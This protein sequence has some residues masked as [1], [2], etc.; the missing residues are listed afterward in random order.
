ML[1]SAGGHQK[2]W[3]SRYLLAPVEVSATTR[4]MP[5]QA[6]SEQL[7][8][9]NLILTAASAI[10]FSREWLWPGLLMFL[11]AT[12]LAGI[13]ERVARLRMEGAGSETWLARLMPLVAA[14]CLLT[15]SYALWPAN[16]WGTIALA[17]TAI[18]FLAALE[19]EAPSRMFPQDLFLAEPKGMAWLMI[20]FALTGK[21]ATGLG[22]LALYAAGSFFFAQR[23]AHRGKPALHED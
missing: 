23:R 9:G 6:T 20:P 11:A 7:W 21:W 2:D 19:V 18:A 12:P 15:L 17:A 22:A 10:C 8:L 14:A 3:V 5:T 4:L 1:K 13:A 16:G